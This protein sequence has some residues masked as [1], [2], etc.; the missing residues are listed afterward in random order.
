MRVIAGKFKG[1]RLFA[2]SSKKVRPALDKVKESIFSILIGVVE[3][4]T[5]LDLFAG[6]G[7]IGIEALSRDAKSCTFVEKSPDV[8]K[9]LKE[10]LERC[11]IRKD[12]E[13]FVA[14]I[15]EALS[16]LK[17]REER[18][19]LIFVDPPYD[20]GWIER[21]LSLIGSGDWSQGGATLVVEHSPRETVK[22][23]Y[24]C[25]RLKD[26]RAYGQTRV[27]FFEHLAEGISK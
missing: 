4:A 25:W 14:S 18:F 26:Q 27:S 23:N 17:Q 5:V 3:G 10:N 12:D 9:A 11:G 8:A 15:G 16:M 20:Q 22:E 2:P 1:R 6:T 21:A 13:V 24:G 7:S 19:D